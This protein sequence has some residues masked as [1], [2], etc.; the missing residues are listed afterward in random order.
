MRIEANILC[1]NESDILAFTINHYKQFCEK[2]IV[3]DNFSTDESRDIA[4]GLG[5][6][7]RQFGIMGQLD[8]YEYTILKNNCWKQSKADYVIV[9]DT[10]EILLEPPKQVNG[11]IF[12]MKGFN[13]FSE[14]GPKERWTELKRGLPDGNYAKHIIFAPSIM[15][16]NFEPGAHQCNPRYPKYSDE[17]LT[18]L[19]FKHALGL[20]RV[21][22]RNALY[23]PRMSQR[24]LTRKLGIQYLFH[25]KQVT[26]YFNSS[27]ANSYDVV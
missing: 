11:N 17:V 25:D 1:W 2:I 5:C 14:T 23:R 7:V 4:L 12:R 21:L 13:I 20:D 22:R 19:H 27:L 10:D 6:E 26:E 16:M 8:D 24:N 15:N 9:C 3:W 18:V